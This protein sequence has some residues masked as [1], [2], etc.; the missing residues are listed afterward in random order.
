MYN[1]KE[2]QDELDLGWMDYGAR[3]YMADIGRWGVVDPLSEKG[4]RWSPYNYA[5]NNPIRFIDPDGMWPL[6]SHYKM[7]KNA[8]REAGVDKKTTKEIA[9]YASTYADNPPKGILVANQVIGAVVG[10]NPKELSKK[11][12]VDYSKTENSQSYTDPAM[13]Q[14]HGT[15]GADENITSE[16]A[17][18]RTENAAKETFE[19]YEGKDLSKLST[20]EKQEIGIAF[21]QIEDTE[22]HKG[23]TWAKGKENTHSNLRDLFGNKREAR[24]KAKE[25]AEKYFGNE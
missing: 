8:L 22:A 7:T 2:K 17:T 5:F 1:G 21:H 11:E 13:Q 25:A 20:E 3:M 18:E 16:Q 10:V 23:A 14:I 12:G 15:K 19:K 6:Y 24:R 9:H 4:R